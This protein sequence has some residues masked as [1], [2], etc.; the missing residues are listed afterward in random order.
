MS[1]LGKCFRVATAVLPLFAA[2]VF[3]AHA[4]YARTADWV[5]TTSCD[6]DAQLPLQAQ[7][8]DVIEID[9]VNCT[10]GGILVN[11]NGTFR[12]PNATGTSSGYF[13]DPNVF[14]SPGHGPTGFPELGPVNDWYVFAADG[15]VTTIYAELQ[16][17]D[18]AGNPLRPGV[19][20]AG[21]GNT[22]N[23]N[24]VL[25]YGPPIDAVP[26]PMWL[27]SYGRN[28]ADAPCREGWGPSWAQWMNAGAGGWTC[29]R[30]IPAYGQ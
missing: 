13:G 8:G 10:A 30:Q 17:T 16:G 18:G 1:S 19:A 4:A 15:Q 6:G 7:P 5:V 27:Q 2:T 23:P 22:G 20:L 26:V 28:A 14:N 9:L 29:D 24:F 12:A 21:I 25:R 11:V 3:T